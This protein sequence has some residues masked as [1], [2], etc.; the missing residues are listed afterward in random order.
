MFFE[1]LGALGGSEASDDDSEAAE[2]ELDSS[3]VPVVNY[4]GPSVEA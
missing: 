3:K 2:L 1:L 4:W